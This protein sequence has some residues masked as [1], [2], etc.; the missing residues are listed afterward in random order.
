[1]TRGTRATSVGLTALQR[2]A[3]TMIM[4]ATAPGQ[5]ARDGTGATGH[6]VFTES[7]LEHIDTANLSINNMM[8]RVC[9]SVKEK[10]S[11]AQ[12]PWQ[13]GSLNV[14]DLCMIVTED[15]VSTEQDAVKLLAKARLDAARIVEQA[16]QQAALRADAADSELEAAELQRESL[17]TVIAEAKGEAEAIMLKAK[18]DAS[19]IRARAI[20]PAWLIRDVTAEAAESA[21]K[22]A[23]RMSLA[24]VSKTL[25]EF[26]A[27]QQQATASAVEWV[28]LAGEDEPLQVSSRAT[29]MLSEIPCAVS[30]VS[31]F[32]A[33]RSGKSTLISFLCGIPNVFPANDGT[34]SYTKGIDISNKFQSLE[35]FSVAGGPPADTTP[36][37]GVGA[38]RIGFADAEGQGDMGNQYDIKLVGGNLVVSRVVLFNW[39]QS[40]QKNKILDE[41]AVMCEVA[42]GLQGGEEKPF[43]H[44]HIVF[45]CCRLAEMK[46]GQDARYAKL[47][48]QE[49]GIEGKED[50]DNAIGVRNQIRLMLTDSFLSITCQLLPK[51]VD[52]ENKYDLTFSKKAIGFDDLT[53]SYIEALTNMRMQIS[54]Q[55]KEPR[56]LGGH[57]LDGA[58]VA[59]LMEQMAAKLT[60]N[61]TFI[62]ATL[63]QE[64]LN[65]EAQEQKIADLKAAAEAEQEKERQRQQTLVRDS[66]K[67]MTE[68]HLLASQL[69]LADALIKYSVALEAARLS[70]NEALVAELTMSIQEVEA[71]Q[72]W[73]DN[74][75][76][77]ADAKLAAGEAHMRQEEYSQAR[78]EFDEGLAFAWESKDATCI[79]QLKSALERLTNAETKTREIEAKQAET[80]REAEAARQRAAIVEQRLSGEKALMEQ[81]HAE[82][83]H[84]LAQETQRMQ[85][86]I[87]RQ[88]REA[89]E[90][91]R[92]RSAANQQALWQMH[93]ERQAASA[94]LIEQTQREEEM[95]ERMRQQQEATDR[96]HAEQLHREAQMKAEADAV[97]LRATEQ[98]RREREETRQMLIEAK[99]Q[100]DAQRQRDARVAA[101]RERELQDEAAAQRREMVKAAE[102]MAAAQ[103]REIEVA[104][105][106]RRLQAEA[107]AAAARE[108]RERQ[109]AAARAERQSKE[110]AAREERQRQED[111]RQ[112]QADAAAAA[113]LRER[114]RQDDARP[115]PKCRV[116]HQ[117]MSRVE[118]AEHGGDDDAGGHCALCGNGVG[119]GVREVIDRGILWNST[120]TVKEACPFWLCRCQDPDQR[121]CVSCTYSQG[122]KG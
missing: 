41:L 98:T 42:K 40:F 16:E 89:D 54:K 92:K 45:Q 20:E 38:L 6:G 97:L 100:A 35:D 86:D 14:E 63:Y 24:R 71:Q 103:R 9:N 110:N 75:T 21:V 114:Q 121:Y 18:K 111:A 59:K 7:L 51:P 122:D 56:A 69:K 116:C 19:T 4:Y 48:G 47:F 31:I 15:G 84:R 53:P 52:D 28:R 23:G 8:V 11:G 107:E 29:E 22:S 70:N 68:G 118:M 57:T 81:Q 78:T 104:L 62:P 13:S 87:E 58:H 12:E 109:E 115:V 117:K 49:K 5:L 79:A 2:P 10:T 36:I 85:D 77:Q 76:K 96:A 55:L 108:Q 60:S 119:Y 34:D 113:E 94:A 64:M 39:N 88:K 82:E 37:T 106:P 46:E 80:Q 67:H 72:L 61:E 27:E 102:E 120:A 93:C 101:A 65:R 73:S 25:E 17:E 1:M 74:L 83:R 32:G 3:G 50:Q 33:A 26:D 105:E 90:L 43:G 66:K 112:R 99:Q 95:L 30:F 44:L 91:E